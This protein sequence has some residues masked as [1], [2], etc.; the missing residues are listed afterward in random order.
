MG[1]QVFD[2]SVEDC[3]ARDSSGIQVDRV[4]SGIKHFKVSGFRPIS[5]LRFGV[6][7]IVETELRE[8][9][10]LEK[11]GGLCNSREPKRLIHETQCRV[12]W[13]RANDV[14][15]EPAASRGPAFRV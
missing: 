9:S 12:E 8:F 1:Y 6:W 7:G 4:L 11:P 14:N 2:G 15:K 10:N 13:Y 3:E 5:G